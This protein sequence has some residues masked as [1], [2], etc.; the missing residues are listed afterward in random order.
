V[1]ARQRGRAGR[2]RSVAPAHPRRPGASADAATLAA[3]IRE[4]LPACGLGGDVPPELAERLAAYL[5]LLDRWNAAYNLTAVRDP[6][7]MIPRHVFDSLAVDAWVRGP[8]ILDVGTGAGLPGIP[9]ALLR[10][11]DRFTLLDSAGKR[12]RFL[13]HVVARLALD[14]VEVV[15]SR[16]ED[17]DGDARFDTVVSRA[18]AAVGDFAA[19][20]GHLCGPDGRLLAMAGTLPA[21]DLVELPEGWRVAAAG[22]LAVPGL[23]AERHAILLKGPCRDGAP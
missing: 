16:V 6:R 15:Q 23:A 19:T 10:P 21:A 12:T 18:F 9:L 13:R 2:G 20:A 1:T 4:G 22:R 14:N 8:R 17:Y 11:A 3:R 7:E 5:A